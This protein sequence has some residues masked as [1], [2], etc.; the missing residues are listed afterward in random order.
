MKILMVTVRTGDCWKMPINSGF[1]LDF[2][3]PFYSVKLL[4]CVYQKNTWTILGSSWN[5]A[6][7]PP[8]KMP[9]CGYITAAKP[10]KEIFYFTNSGTSLEKQAITS[11]SMKVSITDQGNK[12]LIE[13]LTTE[14]RA[15]ASRSDASPAWCEWCSG[16]SFGGSCGY[17]VGS[18]APKEKEKE[19]WGWHRE[20]RTEDTFGV[21]ASTNYVALGTLGK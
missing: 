14:G 18:Y 12:E 1:Q 9:S 4:F 21:R 15:I 8:L 16:K 10:L 3:R 11:E 6:I 17:G 19:G 5:L 7:S 13:T 2:E 20:G